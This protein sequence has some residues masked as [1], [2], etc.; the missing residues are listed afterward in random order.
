VWSD[1]LGNNI[2]VFAAGEHHEVYKRTEGALLKYCNSET[3]VVPCSF[4]TS[5]PL[6][7]LPWCLCH[8]TLL[9]LFSGQLTQWCWKIIVEIAEQ[10]V[11]H[12][13]PKGRVDVQGYKFCYQR[14]TLWH[15]YFCCFGGGLSYTIIGYV[16]VQAVL[17]D[18]MCTYVSYV[19]K[20]D[21][22][23]RP[24]F[25]TAVPLPVWISGQCLWYVLSHN[26]GETRCVA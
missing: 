6:V 19:S 5:S 4:N 8:G 17:S 9:C 18:N 22:K 23:C 7:V 12:I 2:F 11:K 10:R 25:G 14:R 13:G 21:R 15:V 16:N 24:S 3:F 1:Y 26:Y 20:L